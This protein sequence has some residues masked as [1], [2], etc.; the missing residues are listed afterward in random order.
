MASAVEHTTPSAQTLSWPTP[1]SSVEQPSRA[2]KKQ[3]RAESP[4]A[5]TSPTA[6]KQKPKLYF[7]VSED[8]CHQCRNRPCYAF[9]RC[10]SKDE[11]SA[12]HRRPLRASRT[13]KRS[14]P[15]IIPLTHPATLT[16][17][18][19]YP[20]GINY[21]RRPVAHLPQFN[22]YDHLKVILPI[23]G[24]GHLAYQQAPQPRNLDVERGHDDRTVRG[25][26]FGPGDCEDTPTALTEVEVLQ[27]G[28]GVHP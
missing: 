1:S 5:N 22:F 17:S 12:P 13:T 9:M 2:S 6:Q 28:H 24:V 21:R 16:N 11:S 14:A 25:P 10:T 4:T 15:S 8:R 18:H 23:T 3:K 27:G 7:Y 20:T 19:R 26:Q